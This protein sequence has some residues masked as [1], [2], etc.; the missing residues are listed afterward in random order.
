MS[1]NQEKIPSDIIVQTRVTHDGVFFSELE[2]SPKILALIGLFV[3]LFNSIDQ[4]LETEFLY[5]ISPQ[6]EKTKPILNF[7]CEQSTYQKIEIL[8][9]I[10]GSEMAVEL[11]DLNTFRNQL[12]H[13][14]FGMNSLGEISSL[15]TNKGVSRKKSPFKIE[16]ISEEIL[17]NYIQRE[18][19]ILKKFHELRLERINK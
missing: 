9:K 19:D 1:I 13:G 8:E 17:R 12:C 11:K 18:R 10:L 7:L 6:A 16:A 2:K 4:N 14:V 5:V 15:K 3:T